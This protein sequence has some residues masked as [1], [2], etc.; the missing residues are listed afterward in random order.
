MKTCH[1]RFLVNFEAHETAQKTKKT[2]YLEIC[3]RIK[4][5]NHQQPRPTKLL[6]SMYPTVYMYLFS[7]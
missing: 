5:C 4:F 2:C 3:L 6:K 1:K 7:A